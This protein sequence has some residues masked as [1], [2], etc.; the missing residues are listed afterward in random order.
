MLQI[1]L[2]N[3]E[4]NKIN[5]CRYQY[6]NLD[7]MIYSSWDIEQNILKL[8]ILGHF[9]P[10]F[11]PKNPKNQILKMKKFAGYSILHM[12]TKSHKHMMY[13]YWYYRVRQTEFFVILGHFLPFYHPPPLW[14]RKSKFW[15]KKY[16]K[17]DCRYYPFIHTCVP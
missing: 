16:E 17:N 1:F 5:T 11:L 15:K 7:D 10:F 8:E 9:L 4:H 13:G 2:R 6:Q 14:S 3:K 12:C